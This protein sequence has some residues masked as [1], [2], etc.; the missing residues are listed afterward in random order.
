MSKVREFNPEADYPTLVSWWQKRGTPI[1]P[2]EVLPR[3]WVVGAGGVDVAMKFLFLD[4]DGKL[5]QS[6]LLTTNPACAYSRYLRED[7][8]KLM[9]VAE[10]FALE[11]GAF[12]MTALVGP[13][14]GEERLM[15][16]LGYVGNDEPLHRMVAKLLLKGGA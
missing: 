2:L 7:V 9:A 11:R 12:M 8:A 14:T 16:E 13:G 15:K 4:V 10:A 5:A 6:L 3:G 1:L